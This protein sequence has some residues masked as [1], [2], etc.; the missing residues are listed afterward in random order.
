MSPSVLIKNIGM[1][2]KR[3]NEPS[4]MVRSYTSFS[5]VFDSGK[6]SQM[7]HKQR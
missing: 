1:C 7:L 4:R 2:S 6:Y 3:I 5:G